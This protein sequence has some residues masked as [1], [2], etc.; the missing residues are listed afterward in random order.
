MKLQISL[1]DPYLCDF[2]FPLRAT[3]HF[4]GFP[5]EIIT[6]SPQVLAAAEES[7]GMF[8]K[9]FSE[10][11][12][13][14]HIGVLPGSRKECPPPPN[15]RSHRN[16]ISRIADSENYM[17][18]DTQQGFAFGWLTQAAAENRAYLRYHFLE[19]TAW[20]LLESFYLTS[21]HGGCVELDGHGVLLCG[22]SGAGKSSLA[23]ACAQNGWKFLCDDAS[24]LVRK[25]PGRIVV[26]NPYQMRFRKS[27]VDLF[28]ELIHQRV[29][30]R[31]T[32]EMAIE[33]ATGTSA[34]ISLISESSV[35]YIVFLN[36]FDPLPEGLFPF[37]KEIA[38]QWFEQVVCYGEKHVRDA[39][40][41]TLRNLLTA[42]LVEMRYTEMNSAL[43]L[44]ETLVRV[45]PAAAA[46]SFSI[47]GE[48]ENG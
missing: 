22:D 35:D 36:R 37:S 46:E 41:A 47:A 13:Q 1:G 23:Y 30:P 38:S 16:F 40:Y 17:I 25:R 10:P 34:E 19:G 42:E 6:N 26:G 15:F 44:L 8:R 39:H 5:I 24:C 32:G 21:I 2:E 33:L 18:M 20:F 3:Y 29:T 14:I 12:L 48:R 4:V 11:P 27:A 7:W 28:P 31:A 45:G 9:V 43:R